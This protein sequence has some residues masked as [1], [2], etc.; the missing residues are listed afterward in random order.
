MSSITSAPGPEPVLL[1]L[2]IGASL[3]SKLAGLRAFLGETVSLSRGF[4][5]EKGLAQSQ[6]APASVTAMS[7]DLMDVIA[8]S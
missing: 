7:K 3:I 1:R 2:C 5:S 6:P 4:R 8:F